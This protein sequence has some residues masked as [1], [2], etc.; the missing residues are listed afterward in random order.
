MTTPR[1]EPGTVSDSLKPVLEV[2]R[3]DIFYTQKSAEIGTDGTAA[4]SRS[5]WRIAD[6]E[7]KVRAAEL[8]ALLLYRTKNPA[9]AILRAYT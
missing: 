9:K 7:G 3:Q 8:S 2:N 6:T 1:S 4:T 5:W